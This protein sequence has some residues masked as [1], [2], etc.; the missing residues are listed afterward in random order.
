MAVG[1][2]VTVVEWKEYLAAIIVLNV[3]VWIILLGTVGE[4]KTRETR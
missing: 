3:V 2:D 4:D 1:V